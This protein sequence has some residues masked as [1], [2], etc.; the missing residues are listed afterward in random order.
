MID[1]SPKAQ[2]MRRHSDLVAYLNE[3]LPSAWFQEAATY[4]LAH[5]AQSD[6]TTAEELRGAR[7]FRDALVAL[8]EPLDDR[9]PPPDR[10]GT[11]FD[12]HEP[13][14]DVAEK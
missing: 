14:A 12:G 11:V 4:A 3:A 13:I 7:K 5:M 8:G 1:L 10:S 9:E 6:S 2:F